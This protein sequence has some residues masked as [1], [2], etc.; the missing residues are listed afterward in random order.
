M[1]EPKGFLCCSF[2]DKSQTEVPK[3]VAGNGVHICSECVDLSFD[4]LYSPK[5]EDG[6]YLND[7]YR[8]RLGSAKQA[9][10]EESWE[11]TLI[12]MEKSWEETL[13]GMEK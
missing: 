8:M 6:E 5:E 10:N 2:C 11:E 1:I 13:I 4:I 7:L 9:R 12:G 3:L